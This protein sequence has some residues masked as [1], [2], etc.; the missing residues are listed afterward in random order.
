[1]EHDDFEQDSKAVMPE[2]P[3]K[4]MANF[5]QTDQDQAD[6]DQADQDA[7][8]QDQ[9]WCEQVD[10]VGQVSNEVKDHAWW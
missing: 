1:M 4:K 3:G 8:D 9:V 6:W 7:V 2:Y 5:D 10:Q